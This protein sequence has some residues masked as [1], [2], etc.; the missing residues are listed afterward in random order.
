MMVV[1]VAVTK[2]REFGFDT[3]ACASTGN[4]ANS[5]AAHAA[6][7]RLKSYIFIPA[8]LEQGKVLATLVY[9]PTLVAVHGTYDEV[10]RLCSE[11]A[12]KYHW[13]FVNV[14]FRPYYSEGSKTLAFEVAEQL[15]WRLPDAVVVPIASGSMFTKI[16]KGFSE[17]SRA[18]TTLCGST[19]NISN[20]RQFGAD[21]RLS[22]Y[23]SETF[24]PF[25][26]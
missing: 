10:N 15:G 17:L 23:R 12:D 18:R 20:K 21:K 24:E 19:C 13:A 26:A 8:D 7:G 4:L 5:V 2:A 3:V 25:S 1:S 11:I 22:G 14:N 9:S 16:H 6:E